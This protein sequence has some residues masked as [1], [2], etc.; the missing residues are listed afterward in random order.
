ML[1]H[2]GAILTTNFLIRPGETFARRPPLIAADS[3][4]PLSAMTP[5]RLP[6]LQ[7]KFVRDLLA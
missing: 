1:A 5:E 4:N 2:G 7:A 3:H 6:G